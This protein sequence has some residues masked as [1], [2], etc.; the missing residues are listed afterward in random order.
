MSTES[1]LGRPLFLAQMIATAT[2]IAV[3]T[4]AGHG[5]GEGEDEEL[6]V[7]LRKAGPERGLDVLATLLCLAVVGGRCRHGRLVALLQQSGERDEEHAQ[8]DLVALDS[9]A[10]GRRA[11]IATVLH[12]QKSHK[13]EYH[14]VL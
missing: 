9:F 8:R 10:E 11:R 3:T 5:P 1:T 2:T 7:G 14:D 12:E 4:F 13:D 6:R